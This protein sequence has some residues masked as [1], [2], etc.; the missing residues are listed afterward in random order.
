MKKKKNYKLRWLFIGLIGIIVSLSFYFRDELLDFWYEHTTKSVMYPEFGIAIP[1]GYKLHGIDV[2]RYQDNINWGLVKEMKI[3]DVKIDFVFVKATEGMNDVDKFYKRN[4]KK[5]KE[6]KIHRG[7]YLYFLPYRDG[8]WQA[9]NFIKNVELQ[10]GDLPPV[11]DIEEIGRTQPDVLKTRLKD[12]LKT[13]EEHYKAKPILYSYVNFY[14]DYLG[15]DFN[16]YALWAAHY[17]END[18]PR[19]KRN[20]HFWQH[21]DKGKVNG[22]AGDVD[23]NVFNG[24]SAAFVKML[25]K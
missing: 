20:W 12:C 10:K 11:V 18:K 17:F 8:V 2:S 9:K 16:E 23:F 5:L 21:S 19:I 1:T 22:I 15:D 14:E 7:A 4:W 6:K 25:L 3:R 13:L 24:D